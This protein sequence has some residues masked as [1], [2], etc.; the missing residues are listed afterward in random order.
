MLLKE[1]KLENF[2]PGSTITTLFG[3]DKDPP[4]PRIHH[5]IDRAGQGIVTLPF[6]AERIEWI[7]HDGLGCS[8]LRA[9]A[10]DG[11]LELRLLH[12]NKEELSPGILPAAAAGAGLPKGQPIGPTG[13]T[14]LS[15]ARVRPDGTKGDGR[16]VHYQLMLK[17]GHYE[18]ELDELC[19]GWQN[20]D[21]QELSRALGEAFVTEC[22]ARKV[23]WINTKALCRSDPWTGRLRIIIDTA[24]ILGL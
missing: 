5:A 18:A 23:A 1:L 17:P 3:W 19:P 16:H 13:N 20:D 9:F 10:D 21:K 2:F 8:V 12:F 22:A 24:E 4:G 14:G 11:A 6:E 7:D 15:I